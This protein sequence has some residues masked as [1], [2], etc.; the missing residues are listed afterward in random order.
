[1][2]GNLHASLEHVRNAQV[3][4]DLFHV[5]ILA[6]VR[7]VLGRRNVRM[8]PL[9]LVR[10]TGAVSV[11][12]WLISLL[13]RASALGGLGLLLGTTALLGC[14]ET[15]AVGQAAAEALETDITGQVKDDRGDPVAGMTIRLYGLLDNTNLWRGVISTRRAP[16]SIAR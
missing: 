13:V 11:G 6:A 12:A 4:P 3:A 2:V 14:S 1:M 7:C 8:P 5:S 10:S 15:K 16:T 9:L